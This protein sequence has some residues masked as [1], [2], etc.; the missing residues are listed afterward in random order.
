VPT[1]RVLPLARITAILLCAFAI[2]Q[3]KAPAPIP[4][5]MPFDIPYGAPID[6]D[7]AQKAI[8]AAAAEAKKRNRKMAIAVVGP[9][10][11]LVAHATIDGTQYASIEIAQGRHA[12]PRCSGVRASCLPMR[13]T[14]ARLPH[15]VCSR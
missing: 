11:Q 7:S 5:A 15:S 12:P 14:A 13:S 3:A 10:R 8:M 9:A 1:R 4:E 2:A 6:L